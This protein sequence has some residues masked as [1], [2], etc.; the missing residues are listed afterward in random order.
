ME[1]PGKLIVT[2]ALACA[3]AGAL[4]DRQFSTRETVKTQVV[5]Q[6]KVIT[7]THEVIAP[8][9]SKVIDSTVTDNSSIVQKIV[10][11]KAALQPQWTITVGMGLDVYRVKVYSLS[12]DRRILGPVTLGV[13]G[14]TDSELGVRV[15]VQF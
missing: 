5:T 9:G 1:V 4:I 6:Y 12:V 2:G 7:Q 8:D 14:A 15:G 3:V 11:Q 10:D 13:Y